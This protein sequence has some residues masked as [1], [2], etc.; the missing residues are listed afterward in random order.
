MKLSLSGFLFE[1]GYRTQSL[2]FADFAALARDAG[3]EG[4]E[5][6]H[7]QVALDTPAD[8]VAQYRAILDD[9]GL[10]VSCMTPRGLPVEIQERSE[11]FRHYLDLAVRMDCRL[12]KVGG[13]PQWVRQA[14]GLA[15]ERSIALATNTHLNSP[16]ATVAGTE[17]LL[18]EVD[19]PNFGLLYDPMHLAIVGEDYLGA[20]RALYPRI[21]NVL[22]QCVRLAAEG[23]THAISH[24][25]RDYVKIRIDENPIQ[26]W[27]TVLGKLKQLG[28]DG[29][30]TVIEN[31][32]PQEQ[33]EM[34][35][36]RTAEH[37]RELWRRK[38][39][40]A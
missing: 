1:D 2:S 12:L 35:A 8:I 32:W 18:D 22:V 30:I 11:R 15:A 16:T 28:Y 5:L 13:E 39:V 21:R 26:D 17:A 10:C 7:T 33:R 25:G 24:M 14:A 20:I 36:V 9:N 40:Y 29:W 4:V 19:H 34:V 6:R 31:A 38:T 37:I 23:E 27:P 3:Y